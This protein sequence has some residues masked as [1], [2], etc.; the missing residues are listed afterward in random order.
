MGA[1]LP[2]QTA[3]ANVMGEPAT[4]NRGPRP[5]LFRCFKFR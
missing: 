1:A 2:D 4:C 5:H 3:F